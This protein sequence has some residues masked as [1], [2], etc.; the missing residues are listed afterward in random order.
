MPKTDELS[1]DD[2]LFPANTVLL[3]MHWPGM[4]GYELAK[5]LGIQA[6]LQDARLWP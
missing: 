4:G 1:D 3:D 5:R 6:G 2:F